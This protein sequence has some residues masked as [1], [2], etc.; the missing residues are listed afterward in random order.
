MPTLH[1]EWQLPAL[2]LALLSVLMLSACACTASGNARPAPP[3]RTTASPG[4]A[5]IQPT[6]SRVLKPIPAKPA[7]CPQPPDT[8][9]NFNAPYY[10]IDVGN[11][12]CREG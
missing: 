4:M 10:G 5:S 8:V 7:F 3:A 2:R 1:N 12:F 9:N 6:E 11:D